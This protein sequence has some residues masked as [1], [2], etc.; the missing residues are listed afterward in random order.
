M[1]NSLLPSVFGSRSGTTPAFQS[2]H[3]EIERVFD[4]FR[5]VFPGFDDADALDDKG[6]IM[7][8]LDICETDEAVEITA[9]LPGVDEK[10]LDIS[11][12]G[13]VLT[14]SGTKSSKREEEEKN[15]KLVER[16]SGSFYRA[17][18]FAFDIDADTVSARFKDGVLEITMSKPAELAEKT[19]KIKVTK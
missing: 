1:S 19:K 15:Y 16:S 13:N 12:A 11:V 9:E 5:S 7:P 3:K 8:K 17:L 10:D 14:L 4:D 6:K 18:P 2:L